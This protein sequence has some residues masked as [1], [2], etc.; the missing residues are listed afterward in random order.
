MTE[1]ATEVQ[2]SIRLAETCWPIL[3]FVTNFMRQVKHH[4]TPPPDQVRYEALSALRDSDDLSRNDAVTERAWNDR[5]KAMMVY[6]MD[7]K[8]L[9]T[10]WEGRDY[11]FDNPFE[12]DPTVLDHAQSLGGE[13]FFRDCDD[14]QREYELS[15]RR[16]RPDQDELAGV[17][18]LYFICLRLGFKGQYHD[19]P[20]ELADYNPAVVDAVA[21]VRQ[22]TS[23]GDVSHG[24]PTQSGDQGRLQPRQKP[25]DRPDDVHRDHRPVIAYVSFG[26]GQ[27][28]PRHS[29][30][31][32][33]VGDGQGRDR[34]VRR[35]HGRHGEGVSRACRTHRH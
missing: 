32:R 16:D 17:L 6:L 19:R 27:C 29:T 31:C 10:E 9:N 18:S 14:M 35:R 4:A 8:M 1:T 7:Y 2:T 13:E 21:G 23:Q 11:W 22:D 5:V 3:E 34:S 28:G 25:H 26:L 20:Q 33:S 30:K 15:E 12:T 24:L